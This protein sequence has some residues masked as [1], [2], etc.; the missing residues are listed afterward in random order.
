MRLGHKR[1]WIY[2]ALVFALGA[3]LGIWFSKQVFEPGV[4]EYNLTAIILV[5][6]NA[7]IFGSV[8]AALGGAIEGSRLRGGQ[9]AAN[10]TSRPHARVL[11]D[12]LGPTLLAVMAIQVAT[13]ISWLPAAHG[14]FAAAPWMAMVT[15]LLVLTAHLLLGFNLGL[16]LP[17]MVSLPLAMVLPFLWLSLAMASGTFSL[18]FMTGEYLGESC[19]RIYQ[20]PENSALALGLGFNALATVILYFLA[21]VR[22]V[23]RSALKSIFKVALGGAT[24]VGL[25]G[26]VSVGASATGIENRSFRDMTCSG[27]APIICMFPMQDPNGQSEITLKKTWAAIRQTSPDLSNRVIGASLGQNSKFGVA[28]IATPSSS[29][30]DVAF[31]L[32]SG[33]AG[34]PAICQ[35][36]DASYFARQITYGQTL[37]FLLMKAS[38]ATGVNLESHFWQIG[39]KYQ[40]HV[41]K[42]LAAPVSVQQRWQASARKRYLEC[43][44]SSSSNG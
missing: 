15:P 1:S 28:A 7:L 42:L 35:E 37:N 26:L 21:D 18:K 32:V 17:S 8:F 12:S 6:G 38:R 34:Q 36:S 33:Y 30:I 44:P 23:K 24:V 13:F 29:Q 14:F 27:T 22:K 10:L 5:S 20:Q 2:A 11:L 41:Q 9:Y 39:P 16:R 3:P 25:L 4:A 43:P 40:D 31:S 19:C